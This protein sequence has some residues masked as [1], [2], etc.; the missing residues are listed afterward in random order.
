MILFSG[1]FRAAISLIWNLIYIIFFGLG[2]R[3]FKEE[4]WF[5]N[6]K[7]IFDFAEQFCGNFKIFQNECDY[8]HR[9]NGE[10]LLN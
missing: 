10:L 1:Y 9:A 3:E 6:G 2:E 4:I 8:F 7:S 5:F